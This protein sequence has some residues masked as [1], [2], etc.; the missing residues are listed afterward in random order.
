MF[1]MFRTSERKRIAKNAIYRAFPSDPETLAHAIGPYVLEEMAGWAPIPGVR[2][3][4]LAAFNA[5]RAEWARY[6]ELSK[7][8]VELSEQLRVKLSKE[9]GLPG[10]LLY[11][12]FCGKNQHEVRKL[13]A[14]PSVFVCNECIAECN[15]I[16]AQENSPS[17]TGETPPPA[18]PSN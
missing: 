2:K 1:Q 18:D 9:R 3:I 16:L 17:P 10:S 7:L 12:S 11:C 5:L 6:L 4:D 14:G 13:I 8:R 15:D